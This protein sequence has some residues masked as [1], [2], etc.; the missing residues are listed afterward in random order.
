MKSTGIVR[1]I[2]DLGRIVIPV[3]LRRTLNLSAGDQMEIFVNYEDVVLRKYRPG[4]AICG[5]SD[6]QRIKIVGMF[7]KIVCRGCVNH[8]AREAGVKA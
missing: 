1:A 6:P 2:D 3:E 8:I 7:G 4:C 5:E